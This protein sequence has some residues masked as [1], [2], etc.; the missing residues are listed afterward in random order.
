MAKTKIDMYNATIAALASADISTG[1]LDEL[2]GFYAAEVERL[3]KRSMAESAKRAAKKDP[4]DTSLADVLAVVTSDWM[5]V[6]D[7]VEACGLGRGVVVNRLATLVK[8]SKIRKDKDDNGH[9][10]YRKA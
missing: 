7:V 3:T 10:V 9:I 1:E 6:D 8:T 2:V 4:S 5:S